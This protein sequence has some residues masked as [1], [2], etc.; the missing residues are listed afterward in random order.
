MLNTL[1]ELRALLRGTLL[2]GQSVAVVPYPDPS[3]S[4]FALAVTLNGLGRDS[5]TRQAAWQ[6]LRERLP[7]TGR[8]PVVTDWISASHS[9]AAFSAAVLDAELFDRFYFEEEDA[10]GRVG[11]HPADIEALA[12][13]VDPDQCD[14]S[15]PHEELLGTRSVEVEIE[16]TRQRFGVAPHIDDAAAFLAREGLGNWRELE[17]WLLTWELQHAPEPLTLQANGLWYLQPYIAEHVNPA[18]LLMPTTQGENTL[19][20]MHFLGRCL[21]FNSTCVIA[22]MRQ[23]RERYGAEL[24]VHNNTHLELAVARPPTNIDEAFDVAWCHYM[25]AGEGLSDTCMSV[26]EHA[27]ALLYSHDWVLMQGP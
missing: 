3:E 16:A 8:W 13:Q 25:M 9:D 18:I 5:T 10:D 4:R 24:R 14:V 1:D 2:E 22:H 27:R 6:L 21:P 17:R 23:W 26:R 19:A 20:W 12:A 7:D 11:D 15:D